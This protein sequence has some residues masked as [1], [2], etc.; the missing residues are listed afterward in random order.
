MCEWWT[1]HSTKDVSVGL[2][3]TEVKQKKLTVHSWVHF[4]TEF[5][6]FF[7]P[8]GERK[9]VTAATPRQSKTSIPCQS[10]QPRATGAEFQC[11]AHLDGVHLLNKLLDLIHQTLVLLLR[12]LLHSATLSQLRAAE[13]CY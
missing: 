2:M 11:L 6:G 13:T 4:A 12:R 3:K 5:D 10:G 9:T 8:Q 7:F 1:V